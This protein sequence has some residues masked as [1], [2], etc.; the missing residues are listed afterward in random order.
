MDLFSILK[1]KFES[2]QQG[3]HTTGLRA[4]LSH[5]DAAV[6][7]LAR[8]QRCGE[9]AAF[10]DVI[11]RTNQTFEG[12]VKEAYR[13][14]AGK[15]PSG[16]TPFKIEEYLDKEGVFRQ[17]VLALFRNYRTEWRNASAH[18]YKLDFDEGEAFLAITTVASFAALVMDQIAIKLAVS[19]SRKKFEP[20][21]SAIKDRVTQSD[22]LDRLAQLFVEFGKTHSISEAESPRATEAQILG[23]LAGFL[24][25]TATDAQVAI[26]E[27][28][29]NS[30]PERADLVVTRG[31]RR[32]VV[33]V[34]RG[35]KCREQ[36]W[37][38]LV[39]VEHSLLISGAKDGLLYLHSGLNEQPVVS[40]IRTPVPDARVLVV[41]P[42]PVSRDTESA[43]QHGGTV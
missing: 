22:F 42:G 8:G 5:L 31:D 43:E 13:V 35:P 14:I 1:A 16:S 18:D 27:P 38:G 9:E 11:Y 19:H 30:R 10:T 41:A 21:A 40:E 28:M 12:S 23:A 24:G 26:E 32:V 34:K 29:T 6:G 15:D 25:A 36:W 20:E 7:H 17:R 33:E 3:E 4:V 39:K 2:L 37:N